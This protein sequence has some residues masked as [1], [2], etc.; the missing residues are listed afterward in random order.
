VLADKLIK[1]KTDAQ[2][3]KVFATKVRG[4]QALLWA[5]GH[6]RLDFVGLFGSIAGRYGNAGQADY[7]MANE[8]LNRAAWALANA[9]PGCRVMSINWGP[10]DGGMVDD[11]LRAQFEAR[12]VPLIG[13]DIGIDAFM[14]EL[15]ASA[16]SVPEVVFACK[17]QAL[18]DTSSRDHA[19]PARRTGVR[20]VVAA[21]IAAQVA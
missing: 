15:T 1:D 14:R 18:L 13:R 3:R 5:L 16:G 8:V 17:P 21:Q 10:W 9:R 4:L 19:Q 12:G 7:A 2:F 20:E 11:A 6:D